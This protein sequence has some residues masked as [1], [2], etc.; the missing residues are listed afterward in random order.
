M[1]NESQRSIKSGL[2]EDCLLE[3]QYRWELICCEP[4]S[5]RSEIPLKQTLISSQPSAAVQDH[6][7][8]ITYKEMYTHS[9]SALILLINDLRCCA[10]VQM[11]VD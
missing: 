9:T 4:P 10:E 3:V 6:Q 5:D 7:I 11:G 1:S 8:G 2:T